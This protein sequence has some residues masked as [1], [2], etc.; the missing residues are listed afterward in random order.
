MKHF[1]PKKGLVWFFIIFILFSILNGF[2][3]QKNAVFAQLPQLEKTAH[4]AGLGQETEP[5]VIIGKIIGIALTLMGIILIV[6]IIYAGFQWMMSAG[7]PEK[8]T[9]ARELITNA[10]IGLIIIVLAY[11]IAH[12]VIVKLSGVT[13]PSPGST[14][15]PPR[16]PLIPA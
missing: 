6:L 12:F 1:N 15:S 11:A 13:N 4:I 2:S 7:N 16:P 9:K 8:V 5:S 10:L 14:P 3:L